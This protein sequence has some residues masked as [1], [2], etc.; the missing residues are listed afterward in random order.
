[1]PNPATVVYP[2]WHAV[3]N[4][5]DCSAAPSGATPLAA[6]LYTMEEACVMHESLVDQG[7]MCAAGSSARRVAVA[8]E[9]HEVVVVGCV[10]HAER[11]YTRR[12]VTAATTLS[13]KLTQ[14]SSKV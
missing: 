7:T 3:W 11:V 8:L 14:V 1:M 10:K 5:D 13:W 6:A 2:A 4:T 9:C 12:F